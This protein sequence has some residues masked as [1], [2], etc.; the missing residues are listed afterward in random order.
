VRVFGFLLF[1]FKGKGD[2]PEAKATG[3]AAVC[4]KNKLLDNGLLR[5]DFRGAF[6]LCKNFQGGID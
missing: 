3:L 1:I 6:D 5:L 4:L 2:Q